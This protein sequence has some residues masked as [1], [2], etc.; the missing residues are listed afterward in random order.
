MKLLLIVLIALT[1]GTVCCAAEET[2]DFYVSPRGSD[3]WSGTLA[4]PDQGGADGPFATIARARD[5]VRELKKSQSTDIVVLVREGNY[6]L[7]ETVVF[8]LQDSGVGDATI[9]YAAYPGEKPVFSSGQEIKGLKKVTGELPDLP[10]EAQGNV[11]VADVSGRFHSL[12]NAEGL[13]PRARSAGFRTTAGNGRTG[14]RFPEGRLKNWSNLEDVEIVIRASHQ[15]MINILPLASVDEEAQVAQTSI[16][17]TYAMKS[18][19]DSCWVENVLEELDQPGEWVLNTKEGKLYLWPRGE[20]PVLAPQLLELIR[21]EGKIDEM[22]PTDVPVRNLCFR[23]LTF[24]HGDR[25]LFDQDDAG[26]QHDWDVVDKDNALV[27]L[28][29][30][31][32]CVV[33]ECHFLHSGSGAVRVDLYGQGNKISSNHIEHIGGT[34]I[35]LGGYGPGTKDVNKKNLVYNNHIHHVGELYWH[36]P[37][38][39]LWQSGENRVANNLIHNTNY[40]GMIVC[41]MVTKFINGNGREV[42]RS[43]RRH[44][45]GQVP[46]NPTIDDVRPFLHSHDNLIEYNEIHHAM[47]KLGDGNGIYIRGSG[48]GNIIRRNYIHH[49]VAESGAQSGMRTDGGQ[50]DTLI[51]EN[52]IYKCTSQGLILKLNNRAENNIIAYV[53]DGARQAK[54]TE[55]SYLRLTEGPSTGGAIK[56]NIFYHPGTKASFFTESRGAQ[57]KDGDKDYNIYYCAGNPEVSQS[58]LTRMQRE[59]VDAHSLAVDP[60][61]VDPDNGDFRLKPDSPALELGFVPIDL[62]KVGLRNDNK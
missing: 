38:I 44:E 22:G 6:Q 19:G 21:V 57:S 27:R 59:G 46:H 29:G 54:G 20:S 36:S 58:A 18:L 17:A 10:K 15:W 9:T 37:G 24:M 60:M 3:R 13:L 12:F 42:S 43:I 25:Y 41:G 7:E 48:P 30:A 23:G 61:F 51:A 47:E 28:R 53:L 56:R 52:L 4:E 26:V 5:A 31:E 39:L 49:L 2:A 11:L 8:G 34:G 62:S 35:M 45:V 33:E 55:V 1:S 50:M 16:D 14:L 40:C 32:N